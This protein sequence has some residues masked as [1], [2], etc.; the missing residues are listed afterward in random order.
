M[1]TKGKCVSENKQQ[2]IDAANAA[3]WDTLCGSGLAQ[4]LGVVDQSPASLKKFDD[5]YMDFYPYLTRHVPLHEFAGR[6]VVEIGLG[7]GTLSQK[8]VEAHA[9]YL[10][11]DIA[12]GPVG[13]VNHR[14]KQANLPG[15]A[16]QRSFLNNQLPDG[17]VDRVV[18]IGCFHHTGDVQGCFDEAHR[19]LRPGG[20][21]HMMI[22]N[23]FSHRRLQQDKEGFLAELLEEEFG[24]VQVETASEFD[25]AASDTDLEGNA[26]PETVYLSQRQTASMLT[27]FS[28]VSITKENMDESNDPAFERKAVLKTWGNRAG[29]DLYITATK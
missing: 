20:K 26:A 15:Q 4:S 19:I 18:A 21:A 23:K 2:T 16:V 17:S 13:M 14:L 22:Y 3:F 1:N 12:A 10:G 5:W 11:L 8:I 7:Y 29:L 6:K 9:D 25:R 28:H 27:K 24:D